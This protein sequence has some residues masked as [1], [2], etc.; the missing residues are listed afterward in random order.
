MKV[1][2]YCRIRRTAVLTALV[3]AL[4]GAAGTGGL[5]PLRARAQRVSQA[6]AAVLGTYAVGFARLPETSGGPRA[7]VAPFVYP[8]YGGLSGTITL[9]G[10]TACGS[11]TAGSF[12]VHLAYPRLP[13]AQARSGSPGGLTPIPA[14]ISGTTVLTATGAFGADAAHPNDA[15]Y[16][17]VSGTVT[18]GRYAP[19]C[20]GTCP[21]QSSHGPATVCPEGGCRLPRPTVTSVVSFSAVTGYL[22][23][24]SS[25]LGTVVLAFLPPPDTSVTSQGAAAFD[26]LVLSG[27]KTGS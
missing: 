19:V 12:S 10:A 25:T 2:R 21:A 24:Q 15:A 4:L 9:S 11:K 16:L 1:T 7:G 22:R 13:V 20:F 6:C 8:A 26:P 14:P 17:A 27:R 18:Y 5:S 3:A 23:F